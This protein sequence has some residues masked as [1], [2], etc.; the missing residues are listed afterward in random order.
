MILNLAINARDAMCGEGKLTLCTLNN[1]VE[2][3]FVLHHDSVLPG[4]YTMLTVR[5]TGTGIEPQIMEHLFEPFFTTK[6]EGKGTGL[7]LSTVYGAVKQHGGFIS[8]YNEPERGVTFKVSFPSVEEEEPVQIEARA[9]ATA[10]DRDSQTVLL[11]EDDAEVRRLIERRLRARGFTVLSA[12]DGLEALGLAE[13]HPRGIRLLLSDVSMP[14]LNGVELA[15]RFSKLR[16]AVPILLFSG[17]AKEGTLVVD[18]EGPV[19][20]LEKPFT[21]AQLIEKIDTLL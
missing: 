3:P 2:K 6:E 17:T 10:R 13:S 8:V 1:T 5:D 18:V 15:K 20:F 4:E 12:R 11:A 16:P 21:P 19:G 9:V 14:R 7:G